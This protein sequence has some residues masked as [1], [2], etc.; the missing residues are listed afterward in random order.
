MDSAMSDR[1]DIKEKTNKEK[2]KDEDKKL[3]GLNALGLN[4]VKK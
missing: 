1:Y 4:I 2:L 3:D